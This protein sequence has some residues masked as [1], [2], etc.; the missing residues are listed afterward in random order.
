[1]KKKKKHSVLGV[2]KENKTDRNRLNT[3]IIPD[4][5]KKE[6]KNRCRSK[7]NVKTSL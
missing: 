3:M 1:M 2:R 5:K 7:K 4:K 6:T